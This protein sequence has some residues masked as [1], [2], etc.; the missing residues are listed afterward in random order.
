MIDCNEWRTEKRHECSNMGKVK[1]L[2]LWW[3]LYRTSFLV[4]DS[5]NFRPMDSCWRECTKSL[6]VKLWIVTTQC[7]YVFRKIHIINRNYLLVQYTEVRLYKWSTMCSVW[8]T[9]VFFLLQVIILFRSLECVSLCS[10]VS[11]VILLTWIGMP[12]LC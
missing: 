11:A 1:G 4:W 6:T 3:Q 8:G 5:E 10:R 12:I 2:E 9:N 7:V